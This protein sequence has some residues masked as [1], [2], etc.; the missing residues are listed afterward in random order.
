[1]DFAAASGE[2]F[3]GSDPPNGMPSFDKERI[4]GKYTSNLVTYMSNLPLLVLMGLF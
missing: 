4:Y 3:P 1:M 2:P